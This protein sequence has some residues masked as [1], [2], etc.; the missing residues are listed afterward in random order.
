MQMFLCIIDIFVHVMLELIAVYDKVAGK[1]R[2]FYGGETMKDSSEF[3]SRSTDEELSKRFFILNTCVAI[4]LLAAIFVSI[5]QFGAQ[6]WESR[7]QIGLLLPGEKNETGWNSAH[8]RGIK[9]VCDELD[10]DLV[11]RENVFPDKETC[12]KIVHEMASRGVN[13]IIM[14]NGCSL[15]NIESFAAAF[16]KIQ[17]Y[18]IESISALSTSGRYSIFIF[19]GSYLAGILAG[20]HTKTNI[21]GYIAPLPDSEVIQAIN[22]F[23]LG[24]QRVNKNAQVLLNWTGSWNNPTNEE[25]AVQNLKAERVDTLTYHQNGSTVP[26][27][28]ERAGISFISFNSD[29]KS[30]SYCFAALKVNWRAAYLDILRRY[31]RQ[32]SYANYGSGLAQNMIDLE[33]IGDISARERAIFETARYEVKQGRLIFSGEIF[34]RNGIQ[35]CAA[36][37]SISEQYMQEKMNWLIRGV[38]IVGN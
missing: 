25:Q 14:P 5:S 24:V 12:E 36:N 7:R 11:L 19:E 37:E 23:T 10:Y 35:R 1:F 2:I 30:Y 16:P 9:N 3:K 20:L 8:F 31:R 15:S 34:D 18:T 26:K 27:S 4:L 32:T 13:I 28:A 29:Y 21:I 6:A 22:A 33:L 38:R 17:F